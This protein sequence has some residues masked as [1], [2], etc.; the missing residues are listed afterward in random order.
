MNNKSKMKVA[1][2]YK[3]FDIRIEDSDL[4]EIGE[5]QVLINVKSVGVCRS[6]IYYYNSGKIG[7]IT[8]NDPLI[9]GH[10][11][12]GI[13]SEIGNKVSKFKKGDRVAIEPAV[14]CGECEFCLSGNPN[15]C[16]SVKFCGTPP[17]Q[18]ALSEYYLAEQ[19]QLFLIPDSLSFDMGALLEPLGVAIHS[20]NLAKIKLSQSVAIVGCGPIGLLVLQLVKL[21]RLNEIF[22]FDLLDYRLEKAKSLGADY[23]LN[24]NDISLIDKIIDMFSYSK[25]DI[26][27][28][29]S[30]DANVPNQSITLLKPGG[31]LLLIGIMEKDDIL[32]NSSILRRKGLTIKAVRRMKNT[33][34]TAIELVK[35]EK[36]N[37]NSI[38]THNFNLENTLGAFNLVHEY[39]DDV[40]KV[41]I[42][43]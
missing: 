16:P 36:I 21:M 24:N 18:G 27:F 33:Y 42:N 19:E 22:C 40:I 12:S 29:A 32:I 7:D 1:R 17:I 26:I 13:I 11:F 35:N 38:I 8:L 2:L 41:I 28:D 43:P 34:P 14:S 15:L 3:P 5:H 30:G 10:E 37:L 20:V 31:K 9:L 39:K 23:T 4:P 25:I 6:D